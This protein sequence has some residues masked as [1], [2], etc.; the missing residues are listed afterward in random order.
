MDA[1]ADIL[2]YSVTDL[3]V[4]NQHKSIAPIS[5]VKVSGHS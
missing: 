3:I 1:S 5:P 4:E 2:F